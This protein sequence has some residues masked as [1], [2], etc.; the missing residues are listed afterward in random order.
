[1]GRSGAASLLYYL[2]SL[3]TPRGVLLFGGS[4][5]VVGDG[6]GS[7]QFSSVQDG[8]YALGK[9]HMCST[10][11]LNTQHTRTHTHTHTHTHTPAVASLRYFVTSHLKPSKPYRI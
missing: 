1:M 5:G 11:F 9:S 3:I 4:G 6:G 2:S 8:I 10:P 7:V